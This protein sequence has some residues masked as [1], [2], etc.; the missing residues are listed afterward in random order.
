MKCNFSFSH[1]KEI[2]EIAL[3]QKYKFINFLEYQKL[4][5]NKKKLNKKRLC[6]LRH[7]IDY[8]TDKIYTIAKIENDLGIKSTY[9]YLTCAMDYNSRQ[10]ETV[11]V[12][13]EIK[14]M[15]HSVGL[16]LD[17]SWYDNISIKKVSSYYKK[18]KKLLEDILGIKLCDIFSYH[19]PHKLK[20][21]ILNRITPGVRNTYEPI[22][23]SKIKYLSDSQGWYEGC[24][25]KIFK[26]KK[27]DK[28][29][30]L[31]HP[32]IW[33]KKPEINFTGDMA[34]MVSKKTIDYYNHLLKSH[35]V[36]KTNS[37]ELKNL[38]IKRIKDWK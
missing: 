13:K 35:P 11:K 5:K 37:K 17:I 22:F 28:I 4:Y 14:K 29:Q 27:Y 20:N 10:K 36:C 23:F 9:F 19:N 21:F 34:K 6:L 25:C 1:Y 2:L 30:L 31:T 33:D 3:R 24:V 38:I 15:G 18:E 32:Y 7:D 16:H 12:A 26:E 8:E